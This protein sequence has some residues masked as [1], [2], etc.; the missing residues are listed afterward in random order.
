MSLQ[1]ESFYVENNKAKNNLKK[2][3]RNINKINLFPG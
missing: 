1:K 3:L 2:Q